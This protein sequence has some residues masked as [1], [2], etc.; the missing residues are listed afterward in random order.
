MM[1]TTNNKPNSTAKTSP[2]QLLNRNFCSIGK[3]ERLHPGM[4]C[5]RCRKAKIEYNGML[6][7][8]C[9]NCGLTETGAFT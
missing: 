2:G 9:L 7:L 5:P 6:N 4:V 3:G 8:V 1:P